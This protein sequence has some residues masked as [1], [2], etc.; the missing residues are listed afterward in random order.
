M[1]K[2]FSA[3][4]TLRGEKFSQERLDILEQRMTDKIF[5]NGNRNLIV[6]LVSVNGN[7]I[8][9]LY[10]YDIRDDTKLVKATYLGSTSVLGATFIYSRQEHGDDLQK[11]IIAELE[12]SYKKSLPNY[13]VCG[14]I[15]MSREEIKEQR[16]HDFL[17]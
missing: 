10:T 17:H 13:H 7:I 15:A 14:Y 8:N 6:F 12:K 16:L 2:N 9:D 11:A 5:N 3:Y 1:L 4:K